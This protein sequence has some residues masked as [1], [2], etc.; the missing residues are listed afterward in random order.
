MAVRFD[1]TRLLGADLSVVDRRRRARAIDLA[2]RALAAVDPYACTLDAIARFAEDLDGATVLAFGKA[3][4]AMARAACDA[5]DVNG[6]IAI[7]LAPVELPGLEVHVGAHPAP[8]ADAERTGEAVLARARSLGED[9][10]ALC[11]VSGGGSAMLELPKPG[12]SMATIDRLSR[13]LMRR[14]ADVG[15]LNAVRRGL[16]Q[17]KGG[18]LARAIAPAAIFNVVLSDVPGRDPAVVASGPTFP[19]P[20]DDPRGILERYQLWRGLDAST[21]AAILEPRPALAI[22]ARTEIA[23]DNASARRAVS[24]EL[25]DRDGYFD[26][27]ARELG[28]RIASE[29][30]E[31]GWIWGGE[32]TVTVRGS[33]RG[34]RNQELVLGALCAGWSRGL[35]LALGTD[36]VDGSSDAAGALIDP[37]AVRA[38]SALDAAR[39]LEDNA[40]HAFFDALGTQLRCGPT[41]TNVADLCIYLP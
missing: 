7:V 36:G 27:E 17:L 39:A 33:G 6:G 13:E 40:S 37:A 1:R 38:A 12:V 21:I 4:A 8:A 35:L 14:G 19:P 5:I 2:E 22:D 9:D 25:V 31:R 34:G 10:R 11:L 18:G 29:A 24:R 28:A 20:A 15:E 26:G 41:G 32:S 30:H 3:S 16:S 23:G